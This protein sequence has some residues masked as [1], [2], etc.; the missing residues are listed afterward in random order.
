MVR[1]FRTETGT[2][3]RTLVFDLQELWHDHGA[4]AERVNHA[5]AGAGRA[6]RVRG[7]AQMGEQV[8]VYLLPAESAPGEHYVLAPW[9]DESVAGVAA[10]L[11]LR[12]AA[13]FDLVGAI[14]LEPGQHLLL[15]ASRDATRA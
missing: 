9:E 15:L 14:Q 4:V 8:Y 7:L 10:C 2:M 13:G 12:W 1:G 5:C 3:H 11:S 6:M